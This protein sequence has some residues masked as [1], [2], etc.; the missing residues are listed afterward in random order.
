MDKPL[1]QRSLYGGLPIPSQADVI[2]RLAPHFPLLWHTIMDP[3]EEF[4]QYRASDKNF[5]DW[6]E[7]EVAQWLTI[8]ATHRARNFFDGKAG[9]RLLDRHRKLVM[10]VN[11]A[12]AITIKKLT[13]RTK[14]PG[15]EPWMTRSNYLTRSNRDYWSQRR[16]TDAPDVPRVIFGYMLLKEITDIRVY[17]A[18][19]RTRKLGVEWAY[20]MPNQA[21]LAPVAFPPRVAAA[22]DEQSEKGFVITPASPAERQGEEKDTGTG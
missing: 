11:E 22:S 10:V 15:G 5:A 17:V 6:T 9:F 8:Q 12:L 16:A 18:Y 4:L 1:F 7:D 13:N 20:R 3:W 2:A 14:R 19:A 21:P